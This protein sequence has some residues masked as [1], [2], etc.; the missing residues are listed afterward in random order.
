MGKQSG[1]LKKQ[2][3]RINV[4]QQATRDTFKQFLVDTL[5]LALHDPEI[6]GQGHQFGA[7]RINKVLE[8]WMRY[9]DRFSPALG[10]SD[11]ADYWQVK[12]DQYLRDIFGPEGVPDFADRYEWVAKP[13]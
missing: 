5:A 9:Y 6:M 11:E 13:K 4:E 2:K 3:L 1:F 12:L 8:G 10:K 7:A